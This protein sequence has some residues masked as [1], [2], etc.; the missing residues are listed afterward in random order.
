MPSGLNTGT[1]FQIQ[2]SENNEVLI[3][4]KLH[5]HPITRLLSLVL[6]AP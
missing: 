4:S 2:K 6:A 1:R 3:M 5:G